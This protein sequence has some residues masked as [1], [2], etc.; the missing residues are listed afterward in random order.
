MQRVRFNGLLII[1]FRLSEL[2]ILYFCSAPICGYFAN[3]PAAGAASGRGWVWWV[4]ALWWVRTQTVDRGN[5]DNGDNLIW[6]EEAEYYN[7]LR[8]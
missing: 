1:V 5:I 7:I 3:S 2:T 8:A 4:V 6:E